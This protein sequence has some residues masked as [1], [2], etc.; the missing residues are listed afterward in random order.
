[1]SNFA[2]LFAAM[3]ATRQHDRQQHYAYRCR[4]VLALLAEAIE[5]E[6]TLDDLTETNC[7]RVYERAISCGRPVRAAEKFRAR[8]R[9]LMLFS[10]R[11]GF[12][13]DSP[14]RK[15]IKRRTPQVNLVMHGP[16]KYTEAEFRKLL[17]AAKKLPGEFNRRC[18]SIPRA[19]WWR[20]Y[21]S[22]ARDTGLPW[23]AIRAVRGFDFAG[24]TLVSRSR[25]KPTMPAASA[26]PLPRRTLRIVKP[27]RGKRS[28]RMF[29][30]DIAYRTL[31][32]EF[33][34][35]VKL[36]GLWGE[37]AAKCDY[38]LTY[39]NGMR[40]KQRPKPAPMATPVDEF[41]STSTLPDYFEGCY[42]PLRID[43]PNTERLYRTSIKKFGDYLGRPAVLGDFTDDTVARYLAELKRKGAAPHSVSKEYDQLTAL[44]RFAS[45]RRTVET[46]PTLLRPKVPE[47]A[48]VAWTI[49]EFTKLVD[50]AAETDGYIGKVPAG[51]WWKAL[52]LALYDSGE[53]IT[54]MLSIEWPQ[55]DFADRRVLVGAMHRK[56]QTRDVLFSLHDETITALAAIHGE[57]RVFPWPHSQT[58][59]YNRFSKILRRAGLPDDAKSKF[60]RIRRTTASYFEKAGGNATELLDHSSRSVTKK[61]LDA[62]IVERQRA[63]DLLPRPKS[64]DAEGG[65]E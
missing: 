46:Y 39:A 54:A 35:L 30:I 61:Y 49:E 3:D 51:K 42:L 23:K 8:L 55:V 10:V 29:A 15:A 31:V 11:N 60:H 18:G 27:L 50:A 25:K 13:S 65:A 53:R 28:D 26:F 14:E 63:T 62:R 19:A 37:Y 16:A 24:K 2:T 47:Y 4:G 48:P 56:G 44:W 58:Y 9:S 36:A 33:H 21:L 5:R 6:P 22:I 12:V 59:I 20:A 41:D 7:Q 34:K 17:A 32:D 43:K 57:G 52:L 45:R 40:A 1:M 64:A 38:R